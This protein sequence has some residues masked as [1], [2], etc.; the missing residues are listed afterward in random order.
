[1]TDLE[2][3]GQRV[4]RN[5]VFF[6]AMHNLELPSAPKIESTLN[7]VVRKL[8]SFLRVQTLARSVQI[9]YG[10]S[11]IQMSDNFSTCCRE[12]LSMSRSEVQAR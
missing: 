11:N 7:K 5:L 6:N 2:V 3:G 10:D 9:S 4:S 1:M 12:R 8:H